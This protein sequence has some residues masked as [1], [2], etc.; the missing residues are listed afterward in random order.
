MLLTGYKNNRMFL[1]LKMG[2]KYFR[3][4]RIRASGLGNG[5]L[6]FFKKI[7]FRFLNHCQVLRDTP[8]RLF[9]DVPSVFLTKNK[10]DRRNENSFHYTHTHLNAA[11]SFRRRRNLCIKHRK[12]SNY[13]Q[14][15]LRRKVEAE[16]ECTC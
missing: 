6:F 15:L 3:L 12:P 16:H 13:I 2:L 11:L 4:D 14:F 5:K 7:I 9:R 10:K 8:S 1:Y